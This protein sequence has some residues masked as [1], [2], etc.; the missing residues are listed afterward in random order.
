MKLRWS[1]RQRNPNGA[2]YYN[3]YGEGGKI[4]FTIC[5]RSADPDLHNYKGP[6]ARWCVFDDDSINGYCG[7]LPLDLNEEELKATAAAVWR[8][9]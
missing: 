9:R 4:V 8:M 5:Q 2:A 3:I 6:F 1:K 7:D